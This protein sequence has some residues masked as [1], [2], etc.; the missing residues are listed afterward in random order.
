MFRVELVT[1]EDVP[2]EFVAKEKEIES[3][4][5]DLAKKPPQIPEKMVDRQV[6]KGLAELAL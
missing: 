2:V 3:E 6:A 1:V 5:D 4:K